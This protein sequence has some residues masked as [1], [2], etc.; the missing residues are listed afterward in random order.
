MSEWQPMETAPLDGTKVLLW[1]ATGEHEVAEYV[2]TA[3]EHFV[4]VEGTEF[5]RSEK[6]EHTYWNTSTTP[7]AW[8]PLPDPPTR[9]PDH[10]PE[11]LESN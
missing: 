1:I 4:K 6:A 5:Y 2:R 10:V 7:L 3:Y 11:S 8:M 9:L